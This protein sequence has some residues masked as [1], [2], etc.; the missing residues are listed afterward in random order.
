MARNFKQDWKAKCWDEER[1]GFNVKCLYETL[2]A[3]GRVLDKLPDL[4]SL[5]GVAYNDRE[6]GVKGPFIVRIKG[7]GHFA[8]K[9]GKL[10][11]KILQFFWDEGLGWMRSGDGPW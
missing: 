1:G 3:K 5:L 11:Q 9:K 6:D 7:R 4:D 8:V 10:R 2:I